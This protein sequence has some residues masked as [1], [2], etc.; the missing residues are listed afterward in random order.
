MY[1][2][3][4]KPLANGMVIREP[5]NS[6]GQEYTDALSQYTTKLM[7]KYNPIPFEQGLQ[8]LVDAVQKILDKPME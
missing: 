1:A 2:W 7:D 6:R 3:F 8:E 5:A 4:K